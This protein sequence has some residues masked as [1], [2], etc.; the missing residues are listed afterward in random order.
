MT[1]FN[2]KIVQNCWK[3][4]YSLKQRYDNYIFNKNVQTCDLLKETTSHFLQSLGCAVQLYFGTLNSFFSAFIHVF[5]YHSL[6]A[7]P[8]IYCG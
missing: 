6:M 1:I 7:T 2:V 8:N 3:Y 5:F 4:H